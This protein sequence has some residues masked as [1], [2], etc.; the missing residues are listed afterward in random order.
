MSAEKRPGGFR[1]ACAAHFAAARFAGIGLVLLFGFSA[2]FAA[3][4][5][6]P[7]PHQVKVA[8]VGPPQVLRQARA[9]LDPQQFYA[10]PYPSEA[11]AREALRADEVHGAVANGRILLASASGFV[12][13]QKTAQALKA[14]VPQAAV[15]DVAP[16]PAH[17]ARGLSPFVTVTAT[18]M[19][20][21]VFAVL[22]TFAGGRHALRARIV[23]LLLVAGLGGVAVA[24][25]VDTVVGA[26]TDDFWGLAGVIA[27]LILAVALTVHGLGRLVGHAGVGIAALTFMLV[28]ITSSGGGVGQQFEP[29][30]YRAVSQILP[31]G[32]ALTAVR[33][34]VYLSGAHTLG[35]LAVLCAWSAAGAVALL[36]GHHRGPLFAQAA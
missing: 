26:L 32:A 14:L 5:H 15:V 2:V 24:L 31:N 33:N 30:F 20:S 35:A 10:V 27:L 34:D 7:Q 25:S 4:F 11:A 19:A 13:S 12:A 22:L 28:G 21:M 6:N 17:D 9:T 29:G 36:V 16:L 8:I 18:T 1:A 23:A 3:A